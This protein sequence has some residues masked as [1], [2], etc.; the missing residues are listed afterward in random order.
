MSYA[1]RAARFVPACRWGGAVFPIKEGVPERT[2]RRVC[3]PDPMQ[4]IGLVP[5]V[6]TV[7][8][9]LTVGLCCVGFC[10]GNPCSRSGSFFIRHH[11][12]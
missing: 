11:S 3:A 7:H 5:Y 1:V 12:A 9:R 10:L 6:T 2:K 8:D 4:Q